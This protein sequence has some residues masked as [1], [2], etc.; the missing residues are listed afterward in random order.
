VEPIPLDQQPQEKVVGEVREVENSSRSEQIER[1]PYQEEREEADRNMQPSERS[2]CSHNT[3]NDEDEQDEDPR[4]AK[5]RKRDSQ[6]LL[7]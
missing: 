6:S 4:P 5:Q 3:N 2:G 1:R 7:V